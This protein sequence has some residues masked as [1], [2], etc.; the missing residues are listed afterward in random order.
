MK[1]RVFPKKKKEE[2]L[3]YVFT[4]KRSWEQGIRGFKRDRSEKKGD[5]LAGENDSCL[6]MFSW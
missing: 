2:L 5:N 4:K 3:R 6:R 1:E